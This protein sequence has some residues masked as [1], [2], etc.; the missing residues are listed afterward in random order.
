M[1]IQF[2][3]DYLL[4]S[5]AVECLGYDAASDT[6]RFYILGDT[7][8]R[9]RERIYLAL[10][11]NVVPLVKAA[12]MKQEHYLDLTSYTPQAPARS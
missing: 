6:T 7:V 3:Q 11:G 2:T 12:I 1:W 8:G 4:N 5:N 10:H 9:E